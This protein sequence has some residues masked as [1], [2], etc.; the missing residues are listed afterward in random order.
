MHH[1]EFQK[2]NSILRISGAVRYVGAFGTLSNVVFVA[3]LG[4]SHSALRSVA[5]GAASRLGQH[6]FALRITQW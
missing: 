2:E 1:G 4:L 3:V 5:V 6:P